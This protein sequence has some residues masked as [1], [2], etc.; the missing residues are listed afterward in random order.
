MGLL[1]YILKPFKN[2]W[3]HA[4]CHMMQHEMDALNLGIASSRVP[5]S[6]SPERDKIY[7]LRV[8]IQDVR[9]WSVATDTDPLRQGPNAAQRIGGTGKELIRELDPNVLVNGGVFADPQGN[10]VQYSGLECLIRALSRRYAPLAQELEIHV[11]TEILQFRR[12]AGEDTDAVISRFELARTRAFQGANFD[13]SWVGF[14]FLLSNILN[15]HRNQWP[16][17]LAPTQGSLPNTQQQYVDFC[18]YVRRHGHLSDRNVDAVKNLG[19]FS[20]EGQSY[21]PTN[22]YSSFTAQS[23]YV[24]HVYNTYAPAVSVFEV[25]HSEVEDDGFSSC[26]SGTSEPDI[27]DLYNLPYNTAGEKLYLAYR[28]HKRRWRK[29]VGGHKRRFQGKGRKGFRKGGKFGKQG[30]KSSGKGHS[31]GGGKRF[32]K[33]Q[34]FF[35]DESGQLVPFEEPQESLYE[36]AFEPAYETSSYHAEAEWNAWTDSPNDSTVVYLGKGKFRRGNPKGKD[37]KT[38]KCSLCGSE[39]HFIKDCPQNTT[40]MTHSNAKTGHKAFATTTANSETSATGSSSSSNWGSMIYLGN[41]QP[42]ES[43]PRSIIEFADGTVLQL[44]DSVG[45]AVEQSETRRTYYLPS[46]PSGNSALSRS[47]DSESSEIARQFAFV[48]FMPPAFHAQVR[49]A[50]GEALLI[51]IGAWDNLVGSEFVARASAE[52]QSAG[53]GCAWQKMKRMLSVEGVGKEANTTSDEVTLPICLEDGA[54]GTYT[55]PVI[56]SSPLPALLGLNTISKLKGLIDTHN[57]QIIFVGPGGYKLQLS[58]G[59]KLY[60][61]HSAPTGHLMLPC[62][63]WKQAKISP[64]KPG[65]SL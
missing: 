46:A 22:V 9:L 7:L 33:G 12:Q 15:I 64:G 14:S 51:D 20:V 37:G 54:T 56:P 6:W 2:T 65:I 58:P 4:Q 3:L 18:N 30:Q 50:S 53:H 44:D 23:P 26:N 47:G 1:T 8:W 25:E 21:V 59:S 35:A 55:A 63:S 27:S 62:Q 13:M 52:A 39:E 32:G 38:L 19:F 36:P 24:S 11:L 17:L 34:L 29:F 28:H 45:E 42:I 43:D 31:K 61:L 49:L 41:A 16:L 48:W 57:K 40:G 10:P 60:K 5:P